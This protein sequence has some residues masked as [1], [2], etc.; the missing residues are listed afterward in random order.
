M[1]RL[2]ERVRAFALCAA[3][4]ATVACGQEEP[5]IDRV[6]VNVVE[7]AI[8]EGSWYMSR[9]VI[10]VD[11]EGAALGTFTGDAASDAAQTFTAMPR[12]RWKIEKDFLFAY[13]DYELTMGGDGQAPGTQ[14]ADG[15]AFGEPVA[16]FAIEKHF[17]VRRGYDPQ[18][19]EENNVVEENSVDGQWYERPYMRVDW[20]KNLLPGFFGQSY[21][22]NELLGYWKR[23]PA[24]LYVQDASRFPDAWRPRFDRMAC[25]GSGDTSESCADAERDLADDYA[26]GELYHMSFVTQEVLSPGQVP[27]VD[28]A[29][30]LSTGGTEQWCGSI[31]SD[32]PTC[33]AHA[34][35]VRTSFLK[36]SETRQYDPVNWTDTRFDRFGYFRLERD[37]Y[38]RS[39]GTPDDPAYF[40][41][42][43]LNYNVNRHNIW[44]RWRD[45]GDRPIPYAEREVRRIVWYTTPELPAHLVQPS[46]DVV[47]Q[48]NEALMETVRHLRGKKPPH[49]PEVA[50]QRDDPD[51][52]CYCQADERTGA[53]VRPRCPGRY[54]P[55]ETREEAEARGVDRPYDCH[56]EVP[57]DA[58]PDLDDPTL[59]DRHFEGWFAARFSGD[60]CVTELRVNECNRRSIRDNHD[61]SDGLSCQER[62][63]LRFKFVSYIDQPGTPFLGVATLRGD[64]V[65]GEI[66]TGDANIG[67]PALD[68]L[69]TGALQT[70]DL[71]RGTLS[72]SEIITGE[73]VRAY[74]ESLGR[75]Q[76]PAQ[77]WSDFSD[78]T[79]A[80]RPTSAAT[81][82]EIDARME[83]ALARIERLQGPE[84]L[85]NTFVDRKTEL[86]GSEIERRLVSGPEALA[87]AMPATVASAGTGQTS[88]DDAVLDQVS[89]FRRGVHEELAAQRDAATRLSRAT[90]ELPNEYV[91]DSVQNFVDKHLDW[92]RA[93]LEFT[94]N[95]LLYRQTQLHEMGHCLGLRHDFGSSA[96]TDHYH[97]DYYGIVERLPLPDP[98]DYDDDGA[99]GLGAEEHAAYEHDLAETR[100]ARERVGIDAA[101]N[102][103]VME[104]TPE[105]YER[106]APLGRYDRAAMLYGY[107]DLVEAYDGAAEPDAPRAVLTNYAG[108]EPCARD[109]D[110]PYAASGAAAALLSERNRDAGL[111]QRCVP[112]PRVAGDRMCSSLDDD[113]AQHATEGGALQPLQ[114]RFCSDER[115]D[116]TLAWCNRFDE[117]ASFRDVVQ[118][119][120]DG[121]DRTYLFS[122][123]RRYRSGFNA[124]TYRASLDRRLA[125][126][127]NVYQNLVFR[128]V[129]DPAFRKQQG[130]FGFYDQFLATTDILNF[131]ARILT[132]P[133]AGGYVYD[134]RTDSYAIRF[135]APDAPDADLP[136]PLG[137]GRHFYST[138]QSG[139]TGTERLENVGSFVEKVWALGLLAERGGQPSYTRD[140]AFYTNF[141]DLFPNEMQQIFNGMIRGFPAA[142]MPRV[143]CDEPGTFPRCDEPRVLYMDFYRGDCSRPETCRPNPAEVTY[144]G[145]PVLDGG[146]SL[147]LQIYAALY[148]LIYFPVFFDTSF[149]NQLFVCIEGQGDCYA[150]DAS[151][152]E[153]VDYVRYTSDYYRR[154]F[155]AWQ[156]E[157]AVGVGEQ[158]SMG[159]AMVKEARDLGIARRALLALRDTDPTYS[160]DDL[161]PALVAATEAIDYALPT[162]PT[163][164]EA[165]ITRIDRRLS[166][167]ESFFNQII[168]FQRQYGIQPFGYYR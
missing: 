54:D 160:V 81:R 65:T 9:V 124:G 109:A 85:A 72:E 145:L 148:G 12:I 127:D 94:L 40:Y 22:L 3:A 96:D 167:L 42:D 18:T 119:A 122:A 57:I 156:V 47:A 162:T 91:D 56:V 11:Y 134:A 4:F 107:G 140:V 142:Y 36:K 38:D 126:F 114:Y 88:F 117:G 83:Q 123:F 31:Y 51:A 151:A 113:L 52:Y 41:T 34:S 152:V 133:R 165:E 102:S 19:G 137:M 50:C 44:K 80:G 143:V 16:A 78:A 46:F 115:A 84:G 146:S 24:D 154:S 130:P 98:A 66:L 168:Q 25:D 112:S 87:L 28:R 93:R 6:G 141:Y 49:Y 61:T 76:P 129:S 59:G 99:P 150:P 7:K 67:G 10:D 163:E 53:V 23:E 121:Y 92:P 14:L 105:W 166:S 108:G 58:E 48:W 125:T 157:P 164:A 128:Y 90:M 60:E 132:Q 116:A 33:T 2:P 161:D 79:E 69:R 75:V 106:L 97:P 5:P 70:Y 110:C 73:N 21:N 45:D 159:F 147:S 103:S 139:L 120:A 100:A 13:R 74:F 29:T 32:A 136:V 26:E 62:G 30:G 89:P 64:P 138:Y 20:S 39:T 63:D 86:V 68:G 158:T 153:G 135:L 27:G 17:D 95:R 35:Y 1:D 43:F 15:E 71:V 104:Y 131:Y 37:G 77:P 111:T 155:L 55:F 118:N 8:F 144:A 101:M 149:Q 82:A